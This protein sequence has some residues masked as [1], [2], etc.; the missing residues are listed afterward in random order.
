MPA[1][2]MIVGIFYTTTFTFLQ[3]RALLEFI[4]TLSQHSYIFS[5]FEVLIKR[6]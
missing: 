3:R 6:V 5:S 4:E 2:S 1:I